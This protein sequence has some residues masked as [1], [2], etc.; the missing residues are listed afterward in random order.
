MA[1]FGLLVLLGLYFLPT[2]IAAARG[3]RNALAI[4]ALN[5][6]LGWSFIGWIIALV[7][8]LS[9]DPFQHVINVSQNVGMP[10]PYYPQ[11]SM[12]QPPQQ[13]AGPDMRRPQSGYPV[14]GAAPYPP[15]VQQSTNAPQ[16][17]EPPRS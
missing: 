15:N 4:A 9:A 8:A 5:F 14:P 1:G 10:P 6:F 2:I 13:Y 11:Q 3:K 12:P 7:W 17:Y 16:Q